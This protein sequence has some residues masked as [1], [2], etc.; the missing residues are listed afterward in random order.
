MATTLGQLRAQKIGDA[1]A[2]AAA[3]AA[4]VAA[5]ADDAAKQAQATASAT[6]YAQTLAQ[7]NVGG[8][9]APNP[10]PNAPGTFLVELPDG[11]G[12]VR[13]LV[14]QGDGFAIPDPAPAA[15]TDPAANPPAPPAAS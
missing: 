5:K 1:Q 4:L 2:A 14:L 15:P 6:A 8:Y 11:N 9:A 3:D 7:P 10:D 12:G 13:Q